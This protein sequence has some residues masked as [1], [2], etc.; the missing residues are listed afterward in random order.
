MQERLSYT[1]QPKRERA[2]YFDVFMAII[3]KRLVW[4][5]ADR[6]DNNYWGDHN[7]VD[8]SEVY[9]DDGGDCEKLQVVI[10]NH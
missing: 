10:E 1:Q 9:L 4:Q 2:K 7:P 3:W 5:E 8:R 6:L